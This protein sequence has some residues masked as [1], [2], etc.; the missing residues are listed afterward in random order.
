MQLDTYR[1]REKNGVSKRTLKNRLSALRKFEKYV[2]EG[3]P[4][5][6]DLEKYVDE[7]LLELYENNEIKASTVR[8]TYKSIKRYYKIVLNM[9]REV[10]HISDFLPVNDSDP[11]DYLDFEELEEFRDNIRGFRNSAIVDIMYFYAR[12]P[13]EVILLNEED[14]DLDNTEVEEVF[15][16]EKDEL[17]EKEVDRP[18]IT[19]NILKKGED[20]PD[21]VK[22]QTEAG[23]TYDVF[24]A[25]F[26]LRGKPLAS[27]KKHMKYR[28]N[29][30]AT[31]TLDGEELDVHPLFVGENSRISYN[32]V[33]KAITQAGDRCKVG[34]NITPKVL[35]H[36]RA[37]HLDWEGKSPGNI[38]RDQLLHDP[39][40]QVIGRYIHDRDADDVRE[41]MTIE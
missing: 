30:T 28:G 17:V 41:V 29:A 3:E 21:T 40:S 26:L 11:G 31:I 19:F 8:E 37:T 9:E 1:R 7:V 18:K 35:R 23:E 27:L 39:D 22:L 4:G 6:E 10:E 15:D 24:R 2:G 38:A 20:H 25:T 13:K 32:T 16:E 12:R 14:I 5:V 36:S 33:Y 34:K